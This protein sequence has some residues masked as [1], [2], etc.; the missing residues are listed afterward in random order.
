MTHSVQYKRWGG[1]GRPE[2][3]NDGEGEITSRHPRLKSERLAQ[4]E[5]AVDGEKDHI[6]I[7][8]GGRHDHSDPGED[9]SVSRR[10]QAMRETEVKGI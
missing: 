7:Q 6:N 2:E 1:K 9:K 5:H 8:R 3:R 10:N 4:L